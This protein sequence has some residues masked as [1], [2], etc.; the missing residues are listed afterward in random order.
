MSIE[1]G[2]RVEKGAIR[3]ALLDCSAKGEVILDLYGGSG[4]TLLAA[5]MTGRR[6]RVME[7]DPKYVDVIVRRFEDFSGKPT[8]L[9]ATGQTFAQVRAQRQAAVAEA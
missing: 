6:A 5:E 1:A 2:K 8:R 4:T 9:A 7:L 3:D